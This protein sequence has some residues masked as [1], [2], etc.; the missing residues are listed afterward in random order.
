MKSFPSILFSTFFLFLASFSGNALADN[1]GC[2]NGNPSQVGDQHAELFLYEDSAEIVI[3]ET[4][5]LISLNE[6]NF[7]NGV[8]SVSNASLPVWSEGVLYEAELNLMGLFRS[9]S[10]ELS[11]AV[12]FDRAPFRTIEMKCAQM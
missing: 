5:F 9:D 12:S 7:Q 1:L 3:Y 6:S 2:S 11:L 10:S 8:L 4:K